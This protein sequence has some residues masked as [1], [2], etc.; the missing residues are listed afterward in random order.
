[1]YPNLK[2]LLSP[3]ALKDNSMK[4]ILKFHKTT[5]HQPQVGIKMFSKTTPALLCSLC[6]LLKHMKLHTHQCIWL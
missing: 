3:V 6:C 2:I 1:M 5:F 4:D